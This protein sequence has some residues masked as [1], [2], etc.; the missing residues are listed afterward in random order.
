MFDRKAYEKRVEWYQHDRFGMFIHWGLY[1]IPARGEWVRSTEE[2][3]IEDYEPFFN[4]FDP[5]DYDPKKWARLAK[6]AGMKYAVLT[7]KHHDGFCLFDSKLTD[8]KCTN[9]KAGRDLVREYLDAFR[10][11][12][13]KVGLYYS[14]IDWHHPDFPHY[15][16]WHHPMRNH[17]ECSNENR[18][19]DRYLTYMHGQVR[20]LCENYGKIDVM[21]FDFSYGEMT[22]EKWKATEL[23]NMVRSLQPDIILDN[24]LEV[25]GEGFGSLAT[26]NPNVY[27]GDFVSPEQIIPPNGLVDDLG[28]P[29]VWEACVTMNNNWGY[30]A[31]DKN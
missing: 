7:A 9:T 2:L 8:Y 28:R 15:G 29:L 12:G 31:K 22:G 4:E 17:P 24:R 11:E 30:N 26:E 21:W 13:I 5:V 14:V 27:S 25:S 6:E 19:F 16:D 10:A 18:D 23:V 3:T 20:E 1:A